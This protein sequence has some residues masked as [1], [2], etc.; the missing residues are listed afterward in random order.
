MPGFETIS[1]MSKLLVFKNCCLWNTQRKEPSFFFD[2][3][4]SK[5]KKHGF[6]TDTI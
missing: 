1:A 6:L 3:F 2:F 5:R 4:L